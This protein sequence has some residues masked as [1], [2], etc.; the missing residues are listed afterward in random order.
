MKTNLSLLKLDPSKF[1][2]GYRFIAKIKGRPDLHFFNFIEMTIKKMTL[3]WS[4]TYPYL[5]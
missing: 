3:K 4:L 5:N 1:K 2:Q